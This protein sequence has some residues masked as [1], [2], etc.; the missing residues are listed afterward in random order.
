MFLSPLGALLAYNTKMNIPFFISS[1]CAAVAAMWSWFTLG[2]GDQR[3]SKK[4]SI[5][6]NRVQ[7]TGV[8]DVASQL[9]RDVHMLSICASNFF[10]GVTL[11]LRWIG[12]PLVMQSP[13]LTPQQSF[14]IEARQQEVTLMLG[15]LQFTTGTCTVVSQL[16]LSRY[17]ER[18]GANNL[19][20]GGVTQ[21]VGFAAAVFSAQTWHVFLTLAFSAVGS[22]LLT[23]AIIN[24]PNARIRERYI[25][26]GA[27]VR[28]AISAW[29]LFGM[30]LT[31]PFVTYVLEP[32]GA[33]SILVAA[34]VST[35][36]QTLPIIFS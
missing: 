23:A 33:R 21:A 4:K 24:V 20:V 10:L 25:D 1:A 5:E 3:Q 29:L 26:S 27:L 30:G 36:L 14:G 34:S 19:V 11:Q 6:S 16:F 22:G 17:M 32:M 35:V 8:R 18:C 28:A 15:Y 7:K 2:G 12:V 13:N 9:A 31:P